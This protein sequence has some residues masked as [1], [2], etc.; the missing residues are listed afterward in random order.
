MALPSVRQFEL[1][2]GTSF[3]MLDNLNGGREPRILKELDLCP[4]TCSFVVI[5]IMVGHGEGVGDGKKK[6]LLGSFERRK[7]E[8]SS[9]NQRLRK[10]KT[11]KA[12]YLARKFTAENPCCSFK[13][14][15]WRDI[16]YH[17]V[18]GRLQKREGQYR[19][20]SRGY[21]SKLQYS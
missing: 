1:E 19:E 2:Q 17:T 14:I 21:L 6:R 5:S 4:A 3:S 13:E 12:I 10:S 15:R 9:N 11:E 16:L 8:A 20:S 7:K 18:P